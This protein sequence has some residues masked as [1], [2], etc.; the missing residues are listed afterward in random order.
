MTE[1][2]I[3]L[4]GGVGGMGAAHELASRGFDVTVF[5][6]RHAPGAKARSF[7]FQGSA[8][9]HRPS[10][11][12]E[13][14]FRFFPGFYRHLAHAMG[15]IPYGSD[16]R[17]VLDNLVVATEVQIGAPTVANCFRPAHLPRNLT[18]LGAAFRFLIDYARD[19]RIPEQDAVYSWT[20]CSSCAPAARRGVWRTP[21]ARA[22]GTFGGGDA[23]RRVRQ[24]P[25]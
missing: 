8:L 12:G 1:H 25:R 14:G 16:E 23:G 4:D 7:P 20:D 21:S 13:H 2:I 9:G 6:P 5:E 11:P 18:D 24:V 15:R 10:L 3:V 19:V 17:T 22:G